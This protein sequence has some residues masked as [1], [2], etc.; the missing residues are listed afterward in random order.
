MSAFARW[1]LL[2]LG[3]LV[4][5]TGLFLLSWDIPAPVEPVEKRLSDE[6]FPR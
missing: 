3:V 1:L 5:G 6:R 4:V 2:L